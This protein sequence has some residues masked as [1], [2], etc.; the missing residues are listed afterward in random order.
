M[1]SYVLAAWNSMR[2]HD[3]LAGAGNMSMEDGLLVCHFL[4]LAIKVGTY[5]DRSVAVVTT[6]Y[7]QMV[8][9]KHCVRFVG[10]RTYD[11]R[12]LIVSSIATLDRFQ[13]VQAQ[14]I[15]VSLVC[16]TPGIVNDI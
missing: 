10:S 3:L 5:P 6:H 14:V 9:L 12:H 16:P 15:L 8:W 7:A 2:A 11:T 4:E 13:A 1:Q